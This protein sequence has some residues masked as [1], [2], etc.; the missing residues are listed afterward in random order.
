VPE[1]TVATFNAHW[2]RGMKRDGW[3][4]FDLV[5]ACAS[6]EADL[7]ALQEVW[8][9]DEGVAQYDE[10]AAA[11][12][13]HAVATPMASA[14]MAPK[15]KLLGRADR[16]HPG[17]QGSWCLA[18]LTRKPIRTTRTVTLPHLPF[19]PWV[20]ALLHA[21]VDVDGTNL[22]VVA[23]HFSHLE[24]GAPLQTRALRRG[25]PPT[26]RPGVLLGDMNMWGWT[27]DAMAP[28]GWRRVVRG[29]TWP[30]H[31]PRHQID[32]V[33]ATPSVEV[34]RAEVLPELPSDH[35]P[36]RARLRVT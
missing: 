20:R 19:D 9:P 18:V 5:E 28:A 30:A 34:V 10:I 35:R 7:I 15:P 36:V 16:P 12:G 11:L 29:K 31:R 26:D 21:E 27:I 32:H 24:F 4:A 23:T 2:G 22:S 14:T 17:S 3:P 13:M 8:A 6:F 33:L 1:L 25:L